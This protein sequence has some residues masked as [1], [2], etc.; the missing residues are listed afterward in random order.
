MSSKIQKYAAK[1]Q[2][3]DISI[4]LGEG[5]T[6]K[7]NLFEELEITEERVQTELLVQASSYAFVG[8]LHKRLLTVMEDRKLTASTAKAKSYLWWKGEENDNGKPYSDDYCWA[9][10]EVDKEYVAAMKEYNE[11]KEKA[12][13]LEICVTAFEE[14]KDLIQTISANNR[15]EK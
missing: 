9:Q 12:G 14:R 4:K 1:S 7:F 11:A 8:M 5:E 15:K 2:L 10:A 13:L 3:M 6:F